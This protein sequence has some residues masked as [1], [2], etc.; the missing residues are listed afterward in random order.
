MFVDILDHVIVFT[1]TS[2]I[3]HAEQHDAIAAG[4]GRGLDSLYSSPLDPISS[5]VF[6]YNAHAMIKF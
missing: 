6:L 2:G 1:T 5:E 3:M 4:G